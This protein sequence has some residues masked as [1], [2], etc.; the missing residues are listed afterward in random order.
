MGRMKELFIELQ[1]EYGQ[2]L[3]G[4]PEVFDAEKYLAEHASQEDQT[5]CQRIKSGNF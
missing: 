3:E 4:L 1:N 5:F 2:E